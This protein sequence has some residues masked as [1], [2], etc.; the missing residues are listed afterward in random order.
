MLQTYEFR[1]GCEVE[2]ELPLYD[3]VAL[4]SGWGDEFS[5]ACGNC[6]MTGLFY[7]PNSRCI[8]AL[9]Q[10]GVDRYQ[11][12]V[13]EHEIRARRFYDSFDVGGYDARA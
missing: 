9:R 11:W 4:C 10:G 12:F 7:R 8:K 2:V 5:E 6:S 1:C 13:E 3:H